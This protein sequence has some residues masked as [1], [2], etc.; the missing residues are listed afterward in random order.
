MV[1]AYA[2]G[3]F[4]GHLTVNFS[5][6]A[7]ESY[8][9]SPI[10]MWGQDMEQDTLTLDKLKEFQEKVCDY[11]I[12]FVRSHILSSIKSTISSQNATLNQRQ[13]RFSKLNHR[14]L[15]SRLKFWSYR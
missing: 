12:I 15:Q 13:F 11:I 6:G 8:S 1:Q 7:V 10:L 9:G 14:N 4:L 2:Y 5:E 3:K